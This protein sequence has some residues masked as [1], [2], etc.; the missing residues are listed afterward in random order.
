MPVAHLRT[1]LGPAL[2]RRATVATSSS[3][4]KA[5]VSVDCVLAAMLVSSVMTRQ[6]ILT[7]L[8]KIEAKNAPNCNV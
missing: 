2:S 8:G 4:G 5:D 6:M 7:R 1:V 3:K